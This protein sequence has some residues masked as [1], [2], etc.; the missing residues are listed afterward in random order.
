VIA[1]EKTDT[2]V[3]TDTTAMT[4]MSAM[5]GGD[6]R[7]ASWRWTQADKLTWDD[8]GLFGTGGRCARH[9]LGVKFCALGYEVMIWRNLGHD[10]FV[11]FD[12]KNG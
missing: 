7:H 5:I 11:G 9:L 4:D 2:T 1:G 3:T 10:T 6:S 12:E 8:M